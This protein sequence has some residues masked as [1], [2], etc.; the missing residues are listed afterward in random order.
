MTMSTQPDRSSRRSSLVARLRWTTLGAATAV[1]LALLSSRS[2]APADRS[3]PADLGAAQSAAHVEPLRDPLLRLGADVAPLSAAAAES[4]GLAEGTALSVVQVRADS[5]A[6]RAG[7][8]A[9]DVITA[10]AGPVGP[11]TAGT[12]TTMA[13]LDALCAAL[14]ERASGGALDFFVRRGGLTRIVHVAVEP[15]DDTAR[16]RDR[17]IAHAADLGQTACV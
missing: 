7:L 17:E 10:I 1:L 12:P 11:G 13:S 6:A 8:H 5:V 9:Q 16:D 14:E 3:V 4:L 2:A 15:L